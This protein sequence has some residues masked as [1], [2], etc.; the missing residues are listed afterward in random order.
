MSVNKVILLG[1][2]GKEPELRHTESGY[3]VTA[4]TLATTEKG[5]KKPDGSQYPDIT[6]WHNIITWRGLADI[7]SKYVKKGTLIYLE[8]RITSRQ[9]ENKDGV[10]RTQTEIVAEKLEIL[11]KKVEDNSEHSS[12]EE[13][14][15]LPY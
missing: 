1:H 5:Y 8:G 7:A 9:W 12:S 14:S 15:D 4:F 6:E 2:V 13:M 11:S 3:S 10:K